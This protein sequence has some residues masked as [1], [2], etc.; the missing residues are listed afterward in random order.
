L[1][2]KAVCFY[3]SYLEFVPPLYYIY[4]GR[5]PAHGGDNF[6]FCLPAGK[7]GILNLYDF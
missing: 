7:A 6:E 1:R 2:P 5:D 4:C 3:I